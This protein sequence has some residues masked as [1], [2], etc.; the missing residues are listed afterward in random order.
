V[1]SLGTG[2]AVSVRDSRGSRG[3]PQRD[4]VELDVEHFQRSCFVDQLE[5]PLEWMLL[6]RVRI[7]VHEQL[8]EPLLAPRLRLLTRSPK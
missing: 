1:N 7:P 2:T 5:H 3:S 8:P 6:E 4:V